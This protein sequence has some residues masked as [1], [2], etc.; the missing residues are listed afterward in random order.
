[1]IYRTRLLILYEGYIICNWSFYSQPK[2]F[3]CKISKINNMFLW[4][5][6]DEMRFLYPPLLNGKLSDKMVH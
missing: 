5:F 3:I 4:V 6:H 1:M 2:S